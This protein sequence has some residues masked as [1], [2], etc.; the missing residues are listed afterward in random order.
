MALRQCGLIGRIF[1]SQKSPK[2]HIIKGKIF[3][4]LFQNNLIY[5]HQI[6]L[7]FFLFS[8]AQCWASFGQ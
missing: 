6:S 8:R 1:Y 4:R 7:E 2:N 3:D 5:F